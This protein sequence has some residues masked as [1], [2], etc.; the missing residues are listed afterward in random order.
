[1]AVEVAA[2]LDIGDVN[3]VG[4]WLS[5]KLLQLA[6]NVLVELTTKFD[7]DGD[8]DDIGHSEAALPAA[9]AAD[10]YRRRGRRRSSARRWATPSRSATSADGGRRAWRRCG[11]R[12]NL[13]SIRRNWTSVVRRSSLRRSQRQGV[14]AAGGPQDD[15]AGRMRVGGADGRDAPGVDPLEPKASKSNHGFALRGR[16]PARPTRSSAADDAPAAAASA[17]GGGRERLA[18]DDADGRRGGGRGGG[19]RP[20]G[21]LRRGWPPSAPPSPAQQRRRRAARAA[22]PRGRS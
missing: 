5:A 12:A 10:A 1:M 11:G 4:S 17:A 14:G 22:R 7:N 19:G 8:E 15:G 18:I 9:A 16:Q 3:Y 6:D 2:E 21:S 20:A 13:S